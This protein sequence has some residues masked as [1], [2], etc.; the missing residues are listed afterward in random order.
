M[1]TV[2]L[3]LV[4]GRFSILTPFFPPLEQVYSKYPIFIMF[5]RGKIIKRGFAPLKC[6]AYVVPL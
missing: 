5:K 2:M 4:H 3:L 6:P 1:K